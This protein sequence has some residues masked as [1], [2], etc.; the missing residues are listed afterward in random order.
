MEQTAIFITFQHPYFDRTV[1][2]TD[3]GR[4]NM[5]NKVGKLEDKNKVKNGG[6][7]FAPITVT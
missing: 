7:K 2:F 5:G 6:V 1:I 3:R 4:V